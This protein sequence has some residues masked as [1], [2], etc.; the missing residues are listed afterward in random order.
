MQSNSSKLTKWLTSGTSEQP[1]E[2]LE[3]GEDEETPAIRQEHEEDKE[4]IMLDDIP[5]AAPPS[6]RRQKR[7][8]QDSEE[9]LFVGDSDGEKSVDEE[10]A[11]ETGQDADD[12]KKLSLNLAYD[13]FSIYGRILCLVVKRKGVSKTSASGGAAPASSQQM[14]ENWVSTQAAQEAGVDDEVDD[15]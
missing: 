10:A 11:D 14:L 6:R 5:E 4:P 15:G 2:V 7:R 13:G 9:D 1:H 8:R 3:G 12:K